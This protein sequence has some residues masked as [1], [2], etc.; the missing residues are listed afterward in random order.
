MRATGTNVDAARAT[1]HNG[2]I[3][4]VELELD[5]PTFTRFNTSRWSFTWNSVPW[6]AAGNLI[7][8]SEIEET[9]EVKAVGL[10]LVVSAVPDALFTMALDASYD[11]PGRPIRVWSAALSSTYTILDTPELIF[12]GQIDTMRVRKGRGPDSS[13]VTI[14]AEN[15]L[16]RL[17][18]A[19]EQLFS[20]AEQKAR[21]PG[22]R[23]LEFLVSM[24]ERVTVFGQSAR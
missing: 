7:E 12:S 24:S 22:D 21:F 19:E 20:D 1:R 3:C 13:V 4:L 23:G 18:L 2:E 5:G 17:M 16:A 6:P 11:Y 14:Q 8:L 10:R 9:V 15:D